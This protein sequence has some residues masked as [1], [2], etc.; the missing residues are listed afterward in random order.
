MRVM[1]SDKT[2]FAT[3]Q[4]SKQNT[5]RTLSGCPGFAGKSRY[6]NFGFGFSPRQSDKTR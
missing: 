5:T 1:V 4:L 2:H 6:S 3:Y